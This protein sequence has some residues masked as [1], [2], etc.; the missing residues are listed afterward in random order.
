METRVD[1]ST[2]GVGSRVTDVFVDDVAGK[3]FFPA[4]LRLWP[5][6]GLIRGVPLAGGAATLYSYSPPAAERVVSAGG[7]LYWTTRQTVASVDRSVPGP[8]FLPGTWTRA[9]GI[10]AASGQVYWTDGQTGRVYRAP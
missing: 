10:V 4:V 3:A 2:I 7:S 8:F 6:S 5:Q 1:A 9:T